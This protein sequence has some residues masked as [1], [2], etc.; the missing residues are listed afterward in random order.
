MLFVDSRDVIVWRINTQR[1]VCTGNSEWASNLACEVKEGL[2]VEET[3]K[4]SLDL[5]SVECG[6]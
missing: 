6:I 4:Q 5:D 3:L 2:L 1:W